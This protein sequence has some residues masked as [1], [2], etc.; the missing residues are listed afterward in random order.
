MPKKSCDHGTVG[1]A[2]GGPFVK[3]LDISS[4]DACA[5]VVG[6][7][8]HLV[9]QGYQ[10]AYSCGHLYIYKNGRHVVPAPA[11]FLVASSPLEDIPLLL[12]EGSD[13]WVEFCGEVNAGALLAIRELCRVVLDY[14]VAKGGA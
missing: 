3:P 1:K 14:R 7:E 13:Y 8:D 11:L 9:S 2:K 6:L 4:M 10:G 12:A 5:D